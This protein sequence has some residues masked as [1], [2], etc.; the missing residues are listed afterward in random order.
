MAAIPILCCSHVAEWGGAETVLADLLATIDRSRFAL[1]LA[2]PPVGPLPDRAR[3]L[4]VPVHPLPAAGGS[5]AAKLARLPLLARRLRSI[6]NDIGARLLHA[7][8]MIAGYASVLA[9]HRQLPCLWHLHIVAQSRIARLALARAD[10]VVTPCNAN[11]ALLPRL[12]AN[13][14]L[15]VLDN[16]IAPA[17]FGAGGT[18][19]RQQLG[20]PDAAPLLGVVG[21]LDPDK[22]HEVLLQAMRQLP[23]TVHLAVVGSAAFADTLPRVRGYAERL[24]QLAADPQLAGRVH[25]LGERR[26][27]PALMGQFSALVVPSTAPEASPRVIAEAMAA[28]TPVVASAIGGIADMLQGG[29]TGVLVPP[30]QP[31]ALATALGE[32]L[33]DPR[34]RDRYAEQGRS[35]AS[36]RYQPQQFA[37][38]MAAA[39]AATLRSTA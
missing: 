27:L 38:S 15:Q 36:Q 31:A 1:H 17:F 7:N 28:G 25:L 26:D 10:R 37:A 39:Y 2:C 9:R 33:R 21:R 24:Q 16:G 4:A 34:A 20:M 30:G 5:P 23:S 32:L 13:G 6:A 29:D 35:Q 22:G 18:G 12:Y 11:A 3:E 8:T 19:L 14:R